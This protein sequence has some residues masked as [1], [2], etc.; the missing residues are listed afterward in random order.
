M[1]GPDATQTISCAIVS[2]RLRRENS[3]EKS[4]PRPI[5]RRAPRSQTL[6]SALPFFPAAAALLWRSRSGRRVPDTVFRTL[7]RARRGMTKEEHC[8]VVR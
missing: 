7:A 5:T 3:L 6:V 1:V 8:V 4:E 2:S